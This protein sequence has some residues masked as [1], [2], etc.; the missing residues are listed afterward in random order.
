[1]TPATVLTILGIVNGLITLAKDAPSV[2]EEARSLIAKVRP[3]VDAAG[4]EAKAAL[5]AVQAKVT[6][7]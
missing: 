1:M 4:D 5:S 7:P 2:M 6:P 3:H